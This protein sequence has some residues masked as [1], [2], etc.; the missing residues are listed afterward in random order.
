MIEKFQGEMGKTDAE[1]VRNIAI[2]WLSEKSFI[3]DVVKK[4]KMGDQGM[5]E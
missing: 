1:I 4:E 5:Q 2:A 3:S